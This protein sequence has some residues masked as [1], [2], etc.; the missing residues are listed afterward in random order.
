MIFP[1][2]SLEGNISNEW[3]LC[4]SHRYYRDSLEN[5]LARMKTMREYFWGRVSGSYQSLISC[6][7]CTYVCLCARACVRLN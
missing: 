2:I 6:T 4:N 3:L 1:R 7:L 5:L